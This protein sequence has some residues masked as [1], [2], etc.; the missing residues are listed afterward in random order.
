M[1]ANEKIANILVKM[2]DFACSAI[3]GSSSAGLVFLMCDLFVEMFDSCRDIGDDDDKVFAALEEE[4]VKFA[5]VGEFLT[6]D[7]HP[8]VCNDYSDLIRKHIGEYV[9]AKR[10][11]I[12]TG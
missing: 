10:G 12:Q 4:L 7:T 11:T 5:C 8:L 6:N 3:D 2:Y 9:D 1:E